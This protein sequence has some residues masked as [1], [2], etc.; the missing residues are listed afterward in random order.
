[1]SSHAVRISDLR[2][3]TPSEQADT[4]AQLVSEAR[5]PANGHLAATVARIRAFEQRYEMTSVELVTGLRDGRVRE[6]AEIAE[7]LFWLNVQTMA[8][9]KKH[10]PNRISSCT[11]IH[12]NVMDQLLRRGFVLSEDLVFHP[13]VTAT[14]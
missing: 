7:W 1:M 14:C 8:P 6:T 9:G 3:M 5:A 10:Q 11:N 2:T 12:N 13:S 4:L